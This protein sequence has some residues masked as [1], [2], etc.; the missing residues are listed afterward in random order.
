MR[1]IDIGNC[2]EYI[3]ILAS[4][5]FGHW[6]FRRG[7]ASLENTIAFYHSACGEAL[8]QVFVAVDEN[9]SLPMG[10][11]GLMARDIHAPDRPQFSP[12]LVSLYVQERFREQGVASALVQYAEN[13]C[14][15]ARHKALFLNT[16]NAAAFFDGRGWEVLETVKNKPQEKPLV[17]MRR[18]L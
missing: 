4:W 16:R 17:F 2:P 1:V 10:M 3:P 18:I 7:Y 9:R 8:P 14:R 5:D 15:S 11:V 12:Y 13:F 6:G